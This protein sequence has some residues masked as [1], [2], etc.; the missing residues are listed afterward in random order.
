MY[1]TITVDELHE[2]IQNGEKFILVDTRTQHEFDRGHVRDAVLIPY[3]EIGE[4]HEELKAKK[5]DP[6]VVYCRTDNRS[7]VAADTLDDLGYTNVT[8]VLGGFIVWREN[9]YEISG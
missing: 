8:Q 7:E 5:D 2:K 6:I 4:R 3:D 9:G 1:N